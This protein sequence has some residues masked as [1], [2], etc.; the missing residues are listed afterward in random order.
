MSYSSTTDFL[1]L[2]RLLASGGVRAE[3]MPG[4]DYIVAALARAGFFNL[5]VSA[6]APVT[7]QSTTAWFKPAVPSWS[8]EGVLS[9]WNA[10]DGQFE[11][12]TPMLWAELFA[13]VGAGSNT[14]VITAPGPANVNGTADVVLVNQLV[15]API[16]LIVPLAS[17][18]VGP[19]LISD[20]KG[21]SGLG[22]IITAQLSGADIFPGGVTSWQIAGNGGSVFLR[23][24]SGMGYAL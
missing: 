18:K 10:D 3:R 17:T 1:A 13:T 6:T 15:S 19:V 21:D 12:A 5:V 14:Q 20:W 16:T 2:S 22:N 11:P 7:N 9:L 8:F 23:P 4:L 24:I